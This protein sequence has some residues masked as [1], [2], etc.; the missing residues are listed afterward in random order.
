MLLSNYACDVA[1]G[2][3][4]QLYFVC[5]GLVVTGFFLLWSV[6]AVLS[7]VAFVLLTRQGGAEYESMG[8]AGSLMAISLAVWSTHLAVAR[9]RRHGRFELD[10]EAGVLRHYR[11]TRMVGEFHIRDIERVWLALDA[12]DT[13]RMEQPPS[14]LQVRLESGEIFRLAKGSR[15]EL[16]PVCDVMREMG[17]APG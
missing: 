1:Q 5:R 15:V 7:L 9:Y 8:L 6:V 16:A 2:S 4:R 14:W 10:G 13:V 11:G 3:S 17:L 12:T